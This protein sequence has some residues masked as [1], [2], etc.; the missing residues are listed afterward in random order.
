MKP[1]VT[2]EALPLLLIPLDRGRRRWD[3]GAAPSVEG[4]HVAVLNQGVLESHWRLNSAM[5]PGEKYKVRTGKREPSRHRRVPG[6]RPALMFP[7]RLGWVANIH[8]N[9][10]W[11]AEIDKLHLGDEP[12]L[13]P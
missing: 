5:E 11:K 10:T 9:V 4:R 1:G 8:L 3:G 2:L 12:G 13:G 7:M 6:A